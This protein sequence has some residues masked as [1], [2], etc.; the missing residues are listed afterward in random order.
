MHMVR[1]LREVGDVPAVPGGH[2]EC[3]DGQ[4]PRG[5]PA[6]LDADP[7]G[8]GALGLR[9]RRHRQDRPDHDHGARHQGKRS[10]AIE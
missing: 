10:S 5:Q 6:V 1:L 3:R 7:G 2:A 4:L 8:Q 9:G